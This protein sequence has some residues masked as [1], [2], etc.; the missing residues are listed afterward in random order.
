M[1]EKY[2]DLI[3]RVVSKH[4][5]YVKRID[6]LVGRAQS[7]LGEG[8]DEMIMDKQH[9]DDLTVIVHIDT[10]MLSPLSKDVD[11]PEDYVHNLF[12][13]P[14]GKV[15]RDDSYRLDKLIYSLTTPFTKLLPT[16]NDDPFISESFIQYLKY[17]REI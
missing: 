11:E 15:I 5:P 10:N 3:Y 8:V 9:C 2:E 16:N 13:Y 14:Y 1:K 12:N 7:N 6:F 17:E 4:Y